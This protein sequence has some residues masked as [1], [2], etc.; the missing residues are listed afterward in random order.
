MDAMGLAQLKRQMAWQAEQVKH[1]EIDLH[2]AELALEASKKKVEELKK[3]MEMDKRRLDQL[4]I[5]V[6][7]SEEQLRKEAFDKRRG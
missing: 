7:R 6:S 3:K 4:K 2:S 5:E 1:G